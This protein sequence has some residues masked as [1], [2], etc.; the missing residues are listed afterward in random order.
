MKMMYP[1]IA[2]GAMLAAAGAA[3]AGAHQD[4][5]PELQLDRIP[6]LP[7]EAPRDPTTRTL[8]G[9]IA[10]GTAPGTYILTNIA[11]DAR[12][13]A[14]EAFDR[15]S[16]TLSGIDVDVSKHVGHSVSLTGRYGTEGLGAPPSGTEKTP[17]AAES[18]S[19]GDQRTARTFRVTSVEMVSDSCS[20]PAD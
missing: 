6:E 12:T 17:S 10:R 14:R 3:A 20:E 5:I 13:T 8:A 4:R 18:V 1:A 15:A 11:R 19:P 16:V 7:R 9:C 2:L